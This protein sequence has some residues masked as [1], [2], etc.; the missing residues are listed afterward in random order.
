[1]SYKITWFIPVK[2][3]KFDAM[4]ASIWI[5]CL[6]LLPYLEEKG[7][8]CK[9]NDPDAE[10]D[11]CIFIRWQDETA[12]EIA[13]QQ[14]RKGRR[15][16]FDLCVNYFDETGLFEGGYGSPAERVEECRR[17]VEIADVI[18]CASSF[19]AQRARDYH[20]WVVYLP[21]SIDS[22]HFRLRKPEHDFMEEE[23]H[24]IWS[25]ISSKAMELEPILPLLRRHHVPLI[26]I[27]DQ[28][29]QLSMDYRFVRWSHKTFPRHIL[30]GE[31][32]VAPRRVDNPY[33]LGHS[34][35]KIGAFMAEGVPAI[36]SPV[37]SYTEVLGDGDSGILCQSEADWD[38]ALDTIIHDRGMLINWSRHASDRMRRYYTDHVADQYVAVFK[39]LCPS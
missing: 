7:V 21:D 9:V 30:D 36:A 35:F 20:P 29:P 25:G 4:S 11:I 1:M 22:R 28:K 16:I 12:F 31:V 6:Q 8:K 19:I 15:I 27:S 24:A 26:V 2:H 18:T 34:L 39:E 33:D 37:P 32:C 38:R 5:R 17:M 3:R 13:R 23:I 10:A 14:K